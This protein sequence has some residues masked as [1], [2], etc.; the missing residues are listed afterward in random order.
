MTPRAFF[1]G[2]STAAIARDLLGRK[3][4][5]KSKRGIV[6]GYIVETEAYLGERDSTAHAFNGRRS[7]FNEALYG[8]PGT[9]YIYSLRGKYMFNFAAQERD[10]PQGILIRA[11]EPYEGK[12]LMAANRSKNGFELT[13]G[14][15]KFMEA[16]G[17]QDKKLNLTPVNK[18]ALTLELESRRVPKK[19]ISAPRIGVSKRGTATYAPL[20]FYVAG[21]PFVSNTKKGKIELPDYG[22]SNKVG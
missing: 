6:S 19:I 20:R 10:N 18:G 13:N 16:W 2:R 21:N 1:N 15:A 11:I 17:I 12:E 22:W 3:M 7:A 8:P 9:I 4:S 5:Y 14:P